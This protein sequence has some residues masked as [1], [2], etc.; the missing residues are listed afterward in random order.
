M[1]D[2][3]TTVLG[4]VLGNP[5]N[6]KTFKKYI[7]KMKLD[8]AER[9]RILYQLV[10]DILKRPL[11]EVLA[12]LKEN[13]VGWKNPMFDDVESKIQEHDDYLVHPFDVAE[14]VAECP[15]CESRRTFSCQ[16]QVRSSDEPMTTFSSCVEC[17]NKWVYS[18]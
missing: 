18:G 4:T 7:D 11:K 6:V 16:K 14:G 5:K 10:G 1:T 12:S 3:V 2:T 8:N 9:D 15:K 17:G 13:R